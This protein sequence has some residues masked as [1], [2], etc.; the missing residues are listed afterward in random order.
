MTSHHPSRPP[1]CPG[2]SSPTGRI[3]GHFQ[4]IEYAIYERRKNEPPPRPDIQE[5]ISS[6][7]KY[8]VPGT[9]GTSD[10]E[11]AKVKISCASG[12]NWEPAKL[13]GK[14]GRNAWQLWAYE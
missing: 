2:S 4:T 8:R 13:L 1:C 12:T 5:V 3:R 9:A 14:P 10:V 6:G 7:T 11:I